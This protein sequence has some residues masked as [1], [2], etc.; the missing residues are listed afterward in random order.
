M[1]LTV[2]SRHVIG[3]EC[4]LPLRR[5]RIGE[6]AVSLELNR[7]INLGVARNGV[8]VIGGAVSGAVDLSPSCR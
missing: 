4:F 5:V 2:E 8:H 6:A 1:K 3:K 7:L